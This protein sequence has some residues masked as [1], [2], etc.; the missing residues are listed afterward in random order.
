MQDILLNFLLSLPNV[1]MLKSL[2]KQ[3]VDLVIS[4]Y[5]LEKHHL[6]EEP[7]G[8]HLWVPVIVDLDFPFDI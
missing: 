8:H 5:V 7:D 2:E 3:S 1:S 4:Q 6:Q